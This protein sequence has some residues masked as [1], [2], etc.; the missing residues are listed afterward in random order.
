MQFTGLIL[1][2]V[3]FLMIGFLHMAVVRIERLWGSQLW[4]GFVFLGLLFGIGSLFVDDILISA[5][6]GVNGFLF[7]WSGPELKKQKERVEKE[8]HS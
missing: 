1:G 4:Q 7:A 5:L 2:V 6:L 3:T 8:Y